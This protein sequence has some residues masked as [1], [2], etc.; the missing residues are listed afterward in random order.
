MRPTSPAEAGRTV[1]EVMI[2]AEDAVWP[3]MLRHRR[4]GSEHV[5]A[6][7]RGGV[8]QIASRITAWGLSGSTPAVGRAGSRR[9]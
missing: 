5:G 9:V 3:F 1:I 4:K 7:A 6:V 2:P 8:G